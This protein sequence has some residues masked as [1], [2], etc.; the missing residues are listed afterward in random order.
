MMTFGAHSGTCRRAALAAF[1]FPMVPMF[2]GCQKGGKISGK[3]GFSD[4]SPS[5][6]ATV[7]LNRGTES[8]APYMETGV[9]GAYGFDGLERTLW[10][11]TVTPKMRSG[12]LS[13]SKTANLKDKSEV[14]LDF[15]LN[16]NHGLRGTSWRLSYDA[17]DGP[18]S[19]S[20]AMDL[21]FEKE[22]G[23]ED[24]Y[25]DVGTFQGSETQVTGSNVYTRSVSGRLLAAEY[26]DIAHMIPGGYGNTGTSLTR[27]ATGVL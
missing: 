23:P 16:T 24:T 11:V 5:S 13:Q 15:V 27:L 26:G 6:Y 4:G 12:Y 17:V 9:D 1:L 2:W 21:A 20:G 8:N 7:K 22:P 18:N 19:Y 3:V 14:V 25:Q 10:T